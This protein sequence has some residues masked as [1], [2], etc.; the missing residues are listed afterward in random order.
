MPFVVRSDSENEHE[1]ELV[2]LSPDEEPGPPP[3][4]QQDQGA[5]PI[6]RRSNRKRKSTAAYSES[7]MSKNSGSKKKKGSSPEVLKSM[8]KIPRTPQAQDNLPPP[9]TEGA[10]APFGAAEFGTLLAGIEARIT[11]KMEATC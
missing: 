10:P 1:A 2:F 9:V 5:S 6:L 11:A 7:D 4:A 3:G 8:P